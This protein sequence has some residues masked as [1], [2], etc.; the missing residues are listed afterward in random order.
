MNIR[1]V[2]TGRNPAGKSVDVVLTDIVMPKMRGPGLAKRLK[3]LLP[4][5]KIVFMTGYL[6]QSA[7]GDDFLQD[8]FFLQKPFSRESIV[9]QI[10]ES[11]KDTPRPQPI[12]KSKP[13]PQPESLPV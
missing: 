13:K 2:I 8:A 4:H 11:L 9:G 7:T 10:N 12:A 1:C 5:L 3:S 6:E